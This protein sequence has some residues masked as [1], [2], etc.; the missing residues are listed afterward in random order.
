MSGAFDFISSTME[1]IVDSFAVL[2]LL[3]MG[4]IF[5]LGILTSNIGMLYLF[6][7]QLLLVPAISFAANVPG[8]ILQWP[9]PGFYM[10]II[11]WIISAGFI[12][13]VFSVSLASSVG[14]SG[15]SVYGGI[16]WTMLL[17]FFN[18]DMSI[19]D[20]FDPYA[21]YLAFTGEERTKSKGTA[22]CG[23]LPGIDDAKWNSQARTSPTS[24]LLHITFFFGFLLSNAIAI[25]SEPIPVLNTSGNSAT[26]AKRQEALN[27]RVNNRKALTIAIGTVSCFVFLILVY[28]RIFR[29][30]CESSF[31]E[32]FVPI[33]YTFLLGYA[34]FY[35]IYKKCGIRP[36]DVLG[37]VQ[38]FVTP[39]MADNPIV[40]VGS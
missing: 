32:L 30:P 34:W 19:L 40:C 21:W 12:F 22:A 23:L 35:L 36:G 33:T 24:W 5:F 2:P 26:D 13:S 37:I 17:Q 14:A 9:T 6:L 4:L 28:L 38:G 29:T 8:G 15:F 1:S 16:L 18:K 27:T 39:D 20:T 25:H 10:T 3:L 11:K 7:G 31:G